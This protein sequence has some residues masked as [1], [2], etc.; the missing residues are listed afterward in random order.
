MRTFSKEAFERPF[1]TVQAAGVLREQAGV[2]SKVTMGAREDEIVVAVIQH[3][4]SF[5]GAWIIARESLLEQ[6]HLLEDEDGWSFTF[7][8]DT[9]LDEVEERCRRFARIALRR[10]EVMQRWA[11]RRQQ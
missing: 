9:S 8:P 1:H 4:L 10:W 5:G 6:I 11:R 3:D 2:I 7:S